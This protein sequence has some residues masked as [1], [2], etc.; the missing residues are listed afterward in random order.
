[1]PT[2]DSDTTL[3]KLPTSYSRNGRFPI[4]SAKLASNVCLAISEGISL[5][6]FCRHSNLSRGF[7]ENWLR[8]DS[9]FQSQYARAREIMANRYADDIVDL[10]D[11]ATP[12]NAHVVRLQVDT[13][14]WVASKLLPK[15]YGDRLPDLNVNTTTNVVVLSE[16]K[17]REL[18]ER[19]KRLRDSEA[20]ET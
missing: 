6:R 3:S 2:S 5:N 14:R 17:T 4:R 18:Q 13:R 9:A 19:L 7:I 15:V 10:S 11:S 12:G 16:E 8:S 20:N 1:M